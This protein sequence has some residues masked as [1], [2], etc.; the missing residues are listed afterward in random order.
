MHPRVIATPHVAGL[1]PAAVEFQS[2]E[3]VDQLADLLAGRMPLGALNAEQAT[4][5]HL[6]LAD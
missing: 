2:R 5:L 6:L 1:T 4:R 3:T